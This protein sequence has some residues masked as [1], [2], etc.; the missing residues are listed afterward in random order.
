MYAYCLK[1]TVVIRTQNSRSFQT[2]KH[3]VYGSALLEC[4]QYKLLQYLH[5]RVNKNGHLPLVQF[6]VFPK[7]AIKHYNKPP[8]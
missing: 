1:V 3:N 5:V 6:V 4:G 7:N 8:Y 2:A